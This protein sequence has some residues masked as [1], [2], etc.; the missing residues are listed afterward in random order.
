ME[1]TSHR[2]K[3]RLGGMHQ[4]LGGK[5]QGLEKTRQYLKVSATVPI[6]SGAYHEE[7]A[8]ITGI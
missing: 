1:I 4:T 7:K 2:G 5:L 8:T 6:F 3:I